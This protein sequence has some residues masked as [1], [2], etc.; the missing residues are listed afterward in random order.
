M[1]HPL[2]TSLAENDKK[3]LEQLKAG[4]KK[5]I[6]GINIDQKCLIRL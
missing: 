6:N 4:F 2:V 1:Y 3:L 5:T